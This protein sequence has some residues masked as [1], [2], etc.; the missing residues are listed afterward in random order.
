[1]QGELSPGSS[2]IQIH[3]ERSQL[4]SELGS[5]DHD[6]EGVHRFASRGLRC[7]V[8]ASEG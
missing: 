4:L 6:H 1:M 7:G 2:V 3:P 8:C 5:D